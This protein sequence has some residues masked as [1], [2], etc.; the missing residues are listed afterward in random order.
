VRVK[1]NRRRRKVNEI[2]SR[3]IV[4]LYLVGFGSFTLFLAWYMGFWIFV[5]GDSPHHG[6]IAYTP[7]WI[8]ALSIFL[9][10]HRSRPVK[11]FIEKMEKLPF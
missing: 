9:I 6:A 8:F 7:R 4:L 5:L 11:N 2:V 10:F 1:R 3:I